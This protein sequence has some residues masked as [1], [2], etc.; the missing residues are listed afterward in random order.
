MPRPSPMAFIGL[1]GAVRE[2]EPLERGR[3]IW[4]SVVVG[5]LGSRFGEVSSDS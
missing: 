2:T 4:A 5:A 1:D 3:T